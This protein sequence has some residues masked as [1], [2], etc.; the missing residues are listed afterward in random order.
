MNAILLCAGFGTRL[1]P[2]T[3]DT[4]KALVDVA[5]RPIVDY[6]IEQLAGWPSLE[7]I[8]VVHNDRHAAAFQA[9]RRHRE[10]RNADVSIRLHND[11][12][13]SDNDRRG[14]VGDLQFVLDRV[15]TDAPAVVAAGDSLYRIALRP[16]LD[17]FQDAP[18][19]CVLALP[20]ADDRTLRHSSVFALDGDRVRGVIHAPDAP[21]SR[22]VS[23]AFY[24]ISPSGLAHVPTYL[25]RGGDPDT[26]GHFIDDL[27]R[28]QSVDAVKRRGPVGTAGDLRYH[29][30]TP[31]EH[32]RA[33]AALTE[34][35]VLLVERAR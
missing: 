19:H 15:G 5:G 21:P 20:G 3:D 4:P 35:P 10:Q 6:L 29:I 17:R 11:G 8:H 18:G 26:L 1:R 34:E 32:A 33:N 31:D 23:P 25:D 24:V 30:N 16:V 9:W 12:V 14:A 2:L 27:A 7:V 22:W 28:H 13:Q